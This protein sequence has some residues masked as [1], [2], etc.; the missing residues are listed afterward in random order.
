MTAAADVAAPDR[1]VEVVVVGGGFGGLRT[2]HELARLR[3]RRNLH[4]TL[5]DQRNHHTFQPLLYQVATAG[6]EPQDVGQGLRQ[7]HGAPRTALGR[8]LARRRKPVHVVMGEVVA[9]DRS[10]CRLVLADGRRLDWDHLVVAGGAVT[11]DFGLPGVEE[12]GWPLKSLEQATHL[13]DHLVRQF[14]HADADP[15][16]V[17]DGT[18]RFVV[19]GG[20]PTGVEMAGAI[21]ELAFEVLARDHPTLDVR[22][23]AEVVLLEMGDRLLPAFDDQLGRRAATTLVDAGVDVRLQTALAEAAADH[24]VL[25][26]GT[27]LD[28][29]TLVWVAGVRPAGLAGMLDSDLQRGGRVRITPT[30]H[31]P[32]DPSVFVIGD[33]AG[34]P[35]ADAL[36]P[37][38]APV[39]QQQG[40]YVAKVI[41]TQVDGRPPPG[42]FT[43]RDK[44]S[45]ATIGRNHAVAQLPGG[46]HLYGYVGW[47][48]WLVLHL[49][50]L[51][52]F[53]NRVS[54]ALS[55]IHN[56]WTWDRSSRLII[57]PPPADSLDAR[58]EAPKGSPAGPPER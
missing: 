19:A 12:F 58:I 52:G 44:G 26:D 8:W 36:L 1:P 17:T 51:V 21:A 28:T 7:I 27:R 9:I 2:V 50:T 33:M 31:L 18:L 35:T 11:N 15:D 10:A 57:D 43:Y 41:G 13:R 54:V 38:V 4:V 20:G 25:A 16:R 14:E 30:L 40:R 47:I 23:H 55:W 39:A 5:V 49:L 37:Q 22:R 6:L 24:V 29:T 45:M 53:R 3:T 32:D 56:W 42:A 48:S 46:I 34:A